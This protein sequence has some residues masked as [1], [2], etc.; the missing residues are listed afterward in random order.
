MV[1]RIRLDCLFQQ[2]GA[3]VA[4][5]QTAIYPR[6]PHGF[7]RPCSAGHPSRRC[8]RPSPARQRA[9]SSSIGPLPSVSLRGVPLLSPVPRCP[10]PP[11]CTLQHHHNSPHL[12]AGPAGP[13]KLPEAVKMSRPF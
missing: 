4:T 5:V 11:N 6:P 1:I 10:R 3:S 13:H 7:P 2:P 9:D 12:G 8:W